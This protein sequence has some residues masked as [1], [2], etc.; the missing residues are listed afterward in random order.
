MP[1]GQPDAEGKA[2][3]LMKPI[4]ARWREKGGLGT[5]PDQGED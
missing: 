5:A 1:H 4:P 3:R 2:V